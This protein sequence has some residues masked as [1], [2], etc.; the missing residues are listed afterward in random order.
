MELILV[1]DH[2]M[3]IC[4]ISHSGEP[5]EGCEYEHQFWGSPGPECV[6]G[7][8]VVVENPCHLR[9]NCISV[10]AI[11]YCFNPNEPD[12]RYRVT[13]LY[14][15]ALI[16]IPWECPDDCFFGDCTQ[17]FYPECSRLYSE[18]PGP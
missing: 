13:T 17:G 9:F 6:P 11:N 7:T 4:M 12:L 15:K 18:C 14:E 3:A 10:I 1:I 2:V 16:Y 8:M 5:E